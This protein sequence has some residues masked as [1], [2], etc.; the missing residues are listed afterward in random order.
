MSDTEPSR[1]FTDGDTILA[2]VDVAA[3]PDRVFRALTTDENERWWG[4]PGVYRIVDWKAELRVG[5]RWSLGV[6][7]P[8]GQV[9]PA[10]GMFLM[11][12]APRKL[13]QTR[14]Y[15][16][17][18]PHL[19]GRET[20]VTFHL[21]PFDAGTHVAVRHDG[22]GGLTAAANEHALGWE[23]LLNWLQAYLRADGG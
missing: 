4:A 1:A 5:G 3:P 17:N 9:L 11:I 16:F 21:Q 8:D 12:D 20:T 13:V 6:L 15:E 7:L 2:G 19:G 18:H 23:R 14:Q 10:S 22:F